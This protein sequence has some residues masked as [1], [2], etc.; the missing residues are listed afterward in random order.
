MYILNYSEE[1]EIDLSACQMVYSP[2][3]FWATVDMINI[4]TA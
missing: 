3:Y 4:Y 1:A 2:M